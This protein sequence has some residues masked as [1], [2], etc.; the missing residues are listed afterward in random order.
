MRRTKESRPG[1]ASW[2][3]RKVIAATTAS[4]AH[5]CDRA[6]PHRGHRCPDHGAAFPRGVVELDRIVRQ[7]P[8]ASGVRRG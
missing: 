3:A 4:I 6:C 8:H 1:Q 2:A 5:R 7:R